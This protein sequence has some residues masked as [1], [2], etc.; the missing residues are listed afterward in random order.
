MIDVQKEI[1]KKFPK[2]A[3]KPNFLSKSLIKIAKKVI[4]ENS[5]NEFLKKQFTPKRFGVYRCCS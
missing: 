4:H 3:K 2:V 1:E 5:I